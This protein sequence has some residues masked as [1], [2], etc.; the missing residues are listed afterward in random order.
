MG[1]RN[2]LGSGAVLRKVEAG[3]LP[4]I[5][6]VSMLLLIAADPE[7]SPIR[8]IRVAPP[9]SETGRLQREGES[10]GTKGPQP[11]IVDPLMGLSPN[12][13]PAESIRADEEGRVRIALD[14]DPQGKPTSCTV[15]QSSGHPRLDE[16]T[17]QVAMERAA[18]RPA[19]DEQGKAVS[20]VWHS[21][22]IAWKIPSMNQA[23][24]PPMESYVAVTIQLGADGTLGECT[25][26]TS[27]NMTVPNAC[28]QAKGRHSKGAKDAARWWKA[29][30]DVIIMSN[31]DV[32]PNISKP[33]WGTRA[34]RIVSAQLMLDG[35][36]DA[37]A[38]ETI[39]SEGWAFGGTACPPGTKLAPPPPEAD[40]S[41][42]RTNYFEMSTYGQFR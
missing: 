31:K 24:L 10:G 33:E 8:V 36:R 16:R 38:C 17:C 28:E 41:K 30:T 29:L 1:S 7:P 27:G 22:P 35:I 40:W 13:Y 39:I 20:S 23:T 26:E 21:R 9:L 37:V 2:C 11:E 42:A 18:F 4:M 32:P 3:G 12:D 34:S 5:D 6:L 15:L 19:R 25:V 14:V